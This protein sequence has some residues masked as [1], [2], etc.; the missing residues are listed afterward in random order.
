MP[1]NYNFN[2]NLVGGKSGGSVNI[3]K[4]AS[5]LITPSTASSSSSKGVYLPKSLFKPSSYFS[6]QSPYKQQNGGGFDYRR[7]PPAVD[8]G[9][10]FNLAVFTIFVCSIFYICLYR[11]RNKQKIRK[12]NELKQKKLLYE[13]NRALKEK[14]KEQNVKR[15]N[16]M[17]ADKRINQMTVSGGLNN[18]GIEYQNPYLIK[19]DN[20]S[21]SVN[22]QSNKSLDDQFQTLQQNHSSHSN[23]QSQSQSQ[24]QFNNSSQDSFGEIGA[25]NQFS[26]D[27]SNF[28]FDVNPTSNNYSNFNSNSNSNSNSKKD[29][30]N[31]DN[32]FNFNNITSNTNVKNEKNSYDLARQSYKVDSYTNRNISAETPFNNETN[33]MNWNF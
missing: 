17:L 21:S 13:F 3:N 32:N 6:Y 23:S 2:L 1:S 25:F 7:L 30:L 18:F 33:L 16:Q 31:F 26:S 20:L 27:F 28:N 5:T 9:L 12:E 8:W 4:L 14:E 22:N 24:S 11:Y 15:Y 10:L 19:N 29:N